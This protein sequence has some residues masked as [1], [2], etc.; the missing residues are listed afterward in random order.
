[1]TFKHATLVLLVAA[2]LPALSAHAANSMRCNSRLIRPGDTSGYVLEQCGEPVSRAYIL[3]DT[4]KHSSSVTRR[5]QEEW[6]YN[7]G[8]RKFMRVLRFKGN[9]LISIKDGEKGY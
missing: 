4:E 7:L 5:T 3:M 9:R 8:P 2:L 1:M 6:V